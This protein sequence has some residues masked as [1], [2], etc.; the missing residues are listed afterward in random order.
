MIQ[1]NCL[2]PLS[3]ICFAFNLIYIQKEGEFM[4]IDNLINSRLAGMTG[5]AGALLSH[6]LNFRSANHSVISENL[7][8]VDTPGYEFRELHFNKELEKALDK[9][10]IQPR[11]TDPR[12]FSHLSGEDSYIVQTT[13]DRLNIDKEMAKM[14]KNNLLYDSAVKLLSKKFQALKAAI[15]AGRR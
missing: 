2:W 1:K 6:A 3:G 14:V 9:T 13:K 15:E 7:A 11:T 10:A 12:H 8:N 4:K 5:K